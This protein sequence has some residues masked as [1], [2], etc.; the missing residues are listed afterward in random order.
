M[1]QKR[2]WIHKIYFKNYKA[3][4]MRSRVAQFAKSIRLLVHVEHLATDGTFTK[5]LLR[6]EMRQNT[7]EVRGYRAC[8]C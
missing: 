6:M 5:K 1:L 3:I 2:L 8:P 7:G 4:L